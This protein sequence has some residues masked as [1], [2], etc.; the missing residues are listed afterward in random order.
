MSLQ[1]EECVTH[2][3]VILATNNAGT[4]CGCICGSIHLSFGPVLL[5]FSHQEF[6]EIVDLSMA[7]VE[8]MK[9]H[10]DSHSPMASAS[11]SGRM[12]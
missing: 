7:A 4:I 11:I 3:K 9:A 5:T 10:A 1:G 6:M 8:H 2:G 12:Q